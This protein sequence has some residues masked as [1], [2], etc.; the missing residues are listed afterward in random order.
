MDK[1]WPEIFENIELST[2]PILYLHS[3]RITFNDGKIWDIDVDKSK[4][5]NNNVKI[6]QSLVKLFD[7]YEDRIQ[8]IDF[9]LDTEKIKKDITKKT[10]KLLK[11]K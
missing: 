1:Q 3:V 11:K 6:E 7:E 10:K 2:I 5:S 4:K 8:H 9:R